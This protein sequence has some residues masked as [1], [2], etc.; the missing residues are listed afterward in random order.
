MAESKL[1]GT[2]DPNQVSLNIGGITITGFMD[3]SFITV[4][5]SDN[6]LYKK[7]V[8]AKGEVSRAKNNNTS[9]EIAFTLKSTSPSNKMLDLLK[10]SPITIPAMVKN[11]SDSKFL[12]I[13]AD[14]WIGT[15]PD[16]EFATEESGIEWVIAASDLNKSHI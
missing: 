15:D 5:R 9:G 8:G 16:R 3:G 12:A 1:I 4:K 11:N 14:C 13:G 10:N 7:H 6:E 2:Y